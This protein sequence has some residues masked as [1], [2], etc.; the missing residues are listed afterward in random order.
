MVES[1]EALLLHRLIMSDSKWQRDSLSHG[2]QLNQSRKMVT[3][4]QASNI[5]MMPQLT[6]QCAAE[7]SQVMTYAR[8]DGRTVVVGRTVA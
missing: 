8:T 7:R 3:S 6:T 5:Y 1:V 4:K 2:Q